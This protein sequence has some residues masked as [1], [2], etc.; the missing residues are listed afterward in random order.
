MFMRGMGHAAN[1]QEEVRGGE[2]VDGGCRDGGPEFLLRRLLPVR[3]HK[4]DD[5]VRKLIRRIYND[6]ITLRKGSSYM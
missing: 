4:S 3:R 5:K 6:V 1:G 2:A